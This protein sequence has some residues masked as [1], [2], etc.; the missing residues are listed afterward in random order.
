MRVLLFLF[1]LF[2]VLEL[3]VL[4]KVGSAIGVLPTLLLLAV[5]ALAGG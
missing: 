3:A 5:S 1:I 2:P 4:I